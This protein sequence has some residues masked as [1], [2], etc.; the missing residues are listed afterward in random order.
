M[1]TLAGDLRYAF[2]NIRRRPGF[3]ALAVLTLALGIGVNSVAFTAVNA[4][5]FHP[6]V[7]KGVDR[8]GWVMLATPG[9]PHGDLSY[10]EFIDTKRQAR[11]FAEVASEG[12]MP[13]A[14]MQ[15]GRAE[16]VWT[17][18]VSD[19]YFRALGAGAIAGRLL[20]ASDASGTELAAVVS[21][22]FWRTRLDGGSIAGRTIVIADRSVSIVGVMP[23]GFQGPGGLFAPDVWLP[24]EKADVLGVPQRMLSGDERW[25]TVIAQM[26]EGVSRPRAD[27]DLAAISAQLA[28]MA[29]AKLGASR[30]LGYFAMRDGHPEVRGLA[31]FVWVAMGVVGLVLLIACFNVAALLFARAAERRREIGIRTALGASRARIVRQLV[32][33]GLVLAAMSGAA[34]LALA[35]WS[36]TLLAAFALPAPIPQRLNLQLD[37]RLLLFTSGMVLLAG[38]L[39]GLLPALQ[40]TKRNLVASMRLGSG[41]DGRRTKTG[42]LFVRAQIAGSTVFLAVALL[43]VRSF[44]NASAVNLGF[45]AE[46]LVIAQLQPSLYGFEG[47]RA[48]AFAEQLAARVAATPGVSVAV[49]D[50]VPY[51]VGYPKAEILST[52]AVDCSASPC[53]PVVFYAVGAR[54]FEAL[55]LPLRAGRDF[56]TAELAT[57]SAVIV[58]EALAARLWPGQPATGQDVML[59][60]ERRHATVVG[61]AADTSLGFSGQPANPTFYRPIRDTDYT[62]GF[63]LLVRTTGVEAGAIKTVRDAAHALAPAMPIASLSTMKENLAV[64]MWPRRTAAGFFLVCGCL[65]LLLATIGLFGVTYFA[66]RQR[67]REFGIRVALGARNATIVA[68]VLRE[69]VRLAVPAAASGLLLAYIA[70]RLLSRGLLG[71][72]AA[73]PLSFALTATIEI[74]VAL[75]ACALP[76]RRAAQSDPIIA[77]RAD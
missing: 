66:V 12:R 52:S 68:Q 18:L 69:G 59:G 76:A 49:A 8:L 14:L 74:A 32:T 46:G 28:P 47:A 57:G 17:L 43:F 11:A 40:S 7:F 3:S 4:L 9:N 20:D 39:P 77:L 30:K 71:V 42:A 6:F 27:A 55:G 1:T 48:T 19:G 25:L 70:G 44:L 29:D 37:M 16:Q 54:H 21:H 65:A 13:L 41:G 75:I 45:P 10:K 50:R 56:T 23:E 61:V 63:S 53:K 64:P 5:L 34:A 58:N 35:A 15:D 22:Q 51:A 2:R 72:A 62:N 33:E 24:L 36:G 26:R 60:S 67:T 38:V 73:D 31:P